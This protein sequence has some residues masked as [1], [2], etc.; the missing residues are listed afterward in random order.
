VL[1]WDGR[2]RD[3]LPAYLP[4]DEA[5]PLAPQ[6]TYGLSKQLAEETARSYTNK[7]GMETIVL[8]TPG[9]VSPEQL[10]AWRLTGRPAPDRFLLCSYI[11]GRDLAR[12]YRQAVER[13]LPGHTLLFICADDSSV[14]EPLST[15]FPRLVPELG[16]M[17]ASLTGSTPSLSNA[18]ARRLLGW[19]PE[20]SWR[21]P[22][23]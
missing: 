13:P 12:A 21:D 11:D 20:H 15:L 4:I 9:V 19:K 8:R 22:T 23:P 5:H 17:A 18:R 16:A 3:F 14:A 7:C 6:D 10:D 2:E 1:G